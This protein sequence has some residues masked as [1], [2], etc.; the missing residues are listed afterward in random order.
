VRRLL[1]WLARNWRL[2]LAALGIA[3]LLWSVVKAEEVVSVVVRGVPVSVSLRDPAWQA[4][5]PPTPTRVALQLTGPVREVL[6][7]AFSHPRVVVPVEDVHDSVLVAG[8]RSGWVHLSG[9]VPRTQVD[10]IVPG[11]VRLHFRRVS[12]AAI[13]GASERAAAA[14]VARPPEAR[15]AA[16]SAEPPRLLGR[17]LPAAPRAAAESAAVRRDTARRDTTRHDAIRP[18]TIRRDTTRARAGSPPARPRH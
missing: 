16:P 6:R 17:P 3:L 7:V 15:A 13:P 8:L 10:D 1:D 9:D 2:K 12:E 4:V 14:P 5:G 18:D 11:S